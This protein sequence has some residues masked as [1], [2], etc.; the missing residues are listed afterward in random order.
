MKL[1]RFEAIID[2]YGAD[3]GRWPEGERADA[4]ELA[5]SSLDAARTLAEARRLDAAL[6]SWALPEMPPHS[7][8]HAA[9]R[10]QIV[11]ATGPRPK[12]W[13]FEWFGFDLRP[14][15][16]WPSAAGVALLTGL[17][18]AVGFG[19]LLQVDTGHDPEDAT[20][21]SALDFPADGSSQ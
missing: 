10:A 9:L 11:A 3:P 15:Q 16:L 17:G 2:A 18:F 12:N 7:A 21:I 8:R 5:R 6:G 14:Q 1:R 19:G 20:I 4:L 13:I